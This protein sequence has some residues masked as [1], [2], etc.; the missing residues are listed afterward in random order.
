[1]GRIEKDKNIIRIWA[2]GK[3]KPYILDINTGTLIGLTGKKLQTVPPIL[4]SALHNVK[5]TSVIS[6]L[7][8]G[9]TPHR[10]TDLYKLADRADALGMVLSYYDLT[11]IESKIEAVN[12][13]ELAD[14]IANGG[15]VSSYMQEIL[16][17]HWVDKMGLEV[18]DHLTERMVDFLY[19][20]YPDEPKEVINR[21][22]YYL[23]RGLWEFFGNDTYRVREFLTT[24]KF[25]TSEMGVP[26]EKGDFFRNYINAKRA[27]TVFKDRQLDT[28]I[29]QHQQERLDILSYENDKFI[30]VVPMTNEELR[31]EG[32]RQH[33]CVGGY[34][35]AIAEG[36]RN[37]VF[38]RRK[39]NPSK[40]YITCDIYK[41]SRISQYLTFGNNRVEE[42]DAMEFYKEYQLHLTTHWGE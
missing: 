35:K 9:T 19:N 25:I 41:D 30:V 15:R 38:I 11:R 6:L 42:T 37:V 34:G 31:I 20:N 10:H 28:A 26:M 36:R 3:V 33:N 5:K 13:K 24:Y 23:T 18:D 2:E 32:E 7:N 39:S 8:E 14:H 1:M 27:H 16:R 29:A 40:N 4:I 21:F 22:A 12:L 17:T